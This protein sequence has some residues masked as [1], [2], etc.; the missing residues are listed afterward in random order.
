MQIWMFVGTELHAFMYRQSNV[1][2]FMFGGYSTRWMTGKDLS[3]RFFDNFVDLG[4]EAFFG[5][6]NDALGVLLDK[7]YKMLLQCLFILRRV[8]GSRQQICLQTCS[9]QHRHLSVTQTHTNTQ[10]RWQV[11]RKRQHSKFVAAVNVL[12]FCASLRQAVMLFEWPKN[13]FAETFLSTPGHIHTHVRT[14]C[15]ST[16]VCSWHS[17]NQTPT[18]LTLKKC[19]HNACSSVWRSADVTKVTHSCTTSLTTDLRAG[20]RSAAARV[21]RVSAPFSNK[22]MSSSMHSRTSITAE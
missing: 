3:Q 9:F 16:I 5:P 14:P 10:Y 6:F 13:R 1:S 7:L 2:S 15:F 20:F 8:W 4:I 22:S 12:S 18:N 19:L 11:R 17:I 21:T